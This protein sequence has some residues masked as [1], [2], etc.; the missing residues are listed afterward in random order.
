[1]FNTHRFYHVMPPRHLAEMFA[2][3]FLRDAFTRAGRDLGPMMVPADPPRPTRPNGD[4]A[5]ADARPALV[6]G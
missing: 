1:M 6:E 3:P 2:D 4:K 5:P